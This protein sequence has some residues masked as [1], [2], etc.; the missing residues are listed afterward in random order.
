MPKTVV[1]NS[2]TFGAGSDE[3]G[4][5]LMGSF[6]RKLWG[7]DN[8]PTAIIFYNSAVKLLAEGSNALEALDG[9]SEA[10]VDLIACGTCVSYF[11]LKDKMAVGRISDMTEIATTLLNSGTVITL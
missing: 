11:K 10:G 7:L 5:Q 6:L 1:I 9:L 2:E 4:Q 3:L 8:K